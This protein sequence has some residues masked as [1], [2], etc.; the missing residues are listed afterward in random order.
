MCYRRI[1]H[2]SFPS[3]CIGENHGTVLDLTIANA[4]TRLNC[5]CINEH[6]SL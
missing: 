5:F 1:K 3:L 4:M 2:G 6:G